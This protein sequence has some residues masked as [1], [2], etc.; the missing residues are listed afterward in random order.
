WGL[1][2]ADISTGEFLTS[3]CG[4]LEYLTQELMR[5]QPAEVLFPTNAP[6][7]GSLLRPGETSPSL[8]P[9]LPPRSEEPSCRE[10]IHPSWSA[11]A[12]QSTTTH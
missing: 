10:S 5:L 12:S 11:L 2:Y 1:A 9:C 7:L 3:Q 8:P 6:D 4:N